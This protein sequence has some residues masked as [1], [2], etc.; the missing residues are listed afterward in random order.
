MA[1]FVPA[2]VVF[3]PYPS[4]QRSRSLRLRPLT[5]GALYGRLRLTPPISVAA[6]AAAAVGVVAAATPPPPPPSS[7]RAPEAAPFTCRICKATVMAGTNSPTACA[8]H[9]GPWLGA[10]N[11][12]LTG[13]GPANPALVRGVS[14]FWD[15]C[16]GERDDPPCAVGWH[17]PYR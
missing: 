10:E 2:P 7:S 13:T 8:R 17:E 12:K 15:C 1:C 9:P 16:G 11:G 5:A 14:Y 3:S 4:Y 6:A